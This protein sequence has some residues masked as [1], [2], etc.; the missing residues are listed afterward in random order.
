VTLNRVLVAFIAG[1]VIGPVLAALLGIE[2]VLTWQDADRPTTQ[3]EIG[4]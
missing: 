3:I 4:R 2:I 1:L